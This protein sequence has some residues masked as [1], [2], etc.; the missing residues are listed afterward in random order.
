MQFHFEIVNSK[1]GKFYILDSRQGLHFIL[2]NNDKRINSLTKNYNPTK[3]LFN[4]NTIKVFQGNSLGK[5]YPSKVKIKFIECSEFQK[6]VWKRL[7]KINQ[8]TTISYSEVANQISYPKAVRA[9]ASAI[10]KN[11]ISIIV[12]CHRVIRKNGLIGGY[13]WGI[14]MKKALLDVE[15]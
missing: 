11:P 4:K 14:K 1:F 12:P 10:G 8:G 3:G 2:K 5:K 15:V 6:L 9:V 7:L 13:A